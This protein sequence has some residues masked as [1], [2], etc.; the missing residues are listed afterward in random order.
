MSAV[1]G[2]PLVIVERPSQLEPVLAGLAADGWLLQR[3]WELAA[4]TWSVER[5]RLVCAGVVADANDAVAALLAAARGAG[6]AVACENGRPD[7]RE[8]FF[9]DLSRFGH[10]E[11]VQDIKAV[12]PLASLTADQHRILE[13]L[14]Q[15]LSLGDCANTL[16][17]SRR[18]AD[19]RLCAA[20]RTLGVCATAQAV[21][22]ARST[23]SEPL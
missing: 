20:R 4:S 15:G 2:R 17:I 23:T 16:H 6:V 9:D 7:L 22:L 1:R 18:T 8:R 12:D 14:A 13:L 21:L 10:V 11:V 3:G 5:L 19:R